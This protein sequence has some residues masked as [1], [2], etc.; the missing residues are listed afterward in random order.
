MTK[1]TMTATG[2]QIH[3]TVFTDPLCCWSWAFEPQL[4]KIKMQ[5]G[6]H[7]SWQYKMC[8]LIPSWDNF[9]DQENSVSRPVQMGPV[10]MHAGQVARMP[11]HH[12]I[13]IKDPPASSYP[14]CVAVKCAQLQSAELGE[15]FLT[16][17][18]QACMAEGRNIAKK[19]V[20]VEVAG[21]L[22]LAQPAFNARQF[23]VDYSQQNALPLFRA[24]MDEVR[25]LQLNRFPALIIKAN[26]QKAIML[27]GYM[28]AEQVL[29][30]IGEMAPLT[31]MPQ[32]RH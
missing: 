14:P 13:W 30:A 28:K 21:K 31:R 20:L 22:A 25:Y 27:S 7:A 17:L 12:E 5:L 23:E 32:T 2:P 3:I 6:Q 19:S 29:K 1:K 4:Q 18:R 11:I 10:W 9:H 8:G 24:D 15:Q 26:N 16:A